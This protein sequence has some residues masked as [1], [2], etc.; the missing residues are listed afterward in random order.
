MTTKRVPSGC[1]IFG[2]ALLAIQRFR[3]RRREIASGRIASG[4]WVSCGD[5]YPPVDS[6]GRSRDLPI[7][8]MEGGIHMCYLRMP[9]TGDPY[10]IGNYE[11]GVARWFDLPEPP[12]RAATKL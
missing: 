6:S 2:C 11:R 1:L 5:R 7:E 8:D 3:A 4:L 9:F 10:W 12:R